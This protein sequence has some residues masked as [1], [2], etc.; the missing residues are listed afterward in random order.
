MSHFEMYCVA[1]AELKAN[2]EKPQKFVELVR[3]NGI[4]EVMGTF[5]IPKSSKEFMNST[6]ETVENRAIHEIAASF[7]FGREK[8]IPVMFQSLLSR[9][10]ITETD[11]PMFHFY[12]KRHIEVDGDSHGPMALKMLDILCGQDEKKWQEAKVAALV[13]LMK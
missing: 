1:M 13:S 3:E 9:M 5:D 8:I 4:S 2:S 7:C 6:F 11:A 10:N 12:L